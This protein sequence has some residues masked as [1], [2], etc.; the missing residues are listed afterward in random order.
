M[1][2]LSRGFFA[3]DTALVARN[4]LGSE[5][6]R[7]LDGDVLKGRIVETEAYYGEEDPPSH[8]SS[9]RTGRSRIMWD[10]PGL[11]YVYLIYGI[12]LMF[13]VVTES[14]GVPGAVL[15]RGVEPLE[16]IGGMKERRD[17]APVESVADGPGKLTEA[18][19]IGK[20][21]NGEDLVE[22][23]ELWLEEGKVVAGDDIESSGRIG[24]S[25][26]KEEEFRFYL[27]GS[28]FVSR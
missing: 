12:H 8:A 20:T 7:V 17:G 15:V 22:S 5:L 16:G 9:G 2:R 27:A 14:S 10:E 25:R 3:R 13:N 26:G 6:V 18:F 1:A 11:A 21:E 23:G 19:G 28:K 4:L 24:I